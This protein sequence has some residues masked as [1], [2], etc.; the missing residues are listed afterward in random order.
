M[1]PVD[2]SGT[3]SPVCERIAQAAVS[4]YYLPSGGDRDDLLQEARLGVAE[5]LER[6]Q[7]E[8]GAF[9]GFAS[10]CARRAVVDAVKAATREK[11]QA[12]NGA[13]SL[14]STVSSEG[15]DDV[16]LREMLADP[17][18]D[19]ATALELREQIHEVGTAIRERLSDRECACLL[20]WVAHGSYP[21][22]CD[23]LGLTD[24]QVDTALQRARWKLQGTGPPSRPAQ[25][26]ARRAETHGY[27]CPSCGGATMKAKA[28]RGRPPGCVVCRVTAGELRAA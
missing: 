19:A 24:K 16:P 20:A 15:G 4:G 21:V 13:V 22:I 5:A 28:G 6:W 12:L 7:P 10:L 26:T 17:A 2:Q 3:W 14:D 18:G 25:A 1:K 9:V 23:L 11:R 27:R 8:R